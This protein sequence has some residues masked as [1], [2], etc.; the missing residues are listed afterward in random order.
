MPLFLDMH[1][2]EIIPEASTMT[3][4]SLHIHSV[5]YEASLCHLCALSLY[6]FHSAVSYS[7]VN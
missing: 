6:S 7:P 5:K 4:L 2:A 3:L 1:M